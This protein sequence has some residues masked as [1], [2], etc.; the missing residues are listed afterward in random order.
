[1]KENEKSIKDVII[2]LTKES[3]EFK[4]LNQEAKLAIGS[5]EIFTEKV[6][7]KGGLLVE[8]P[9]SLPSRVSGIGKEDWCEILDRVRLFAKQAEKAY[10]SGETFA[11]SSLLMHPGGLNIENNDLQKL[12]DELKNKHITS[13]PSE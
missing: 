4:K 11:L 3:D 10:A 5:R 2:I 1:M 13:L 8:L 7:Q 9:S 6:C 12:V